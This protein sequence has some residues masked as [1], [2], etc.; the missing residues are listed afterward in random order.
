MNRAVYF[1]KQNLWWPILVTALLVIFFWKYGNVFQNGKS[2]ASVSQLQFERDFGKSG[3]E[4]S[5]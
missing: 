1:L 3:A 4:G 5:W 2:A